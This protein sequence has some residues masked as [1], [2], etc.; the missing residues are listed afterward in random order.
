MKLPGKTIVLISVNLNLPIKKVTKVE[1]SLFYPLSNLCR[2]FYFITTKF[3]S[4]RNRE[5]LTLQ[6]SETVRSVKNTICLQKSRTSKYCLFLIRWIDDIPK[7][8]LHFYL[9]INCNR[10]LGGRLF[11]RRRKVDNLTSVLGLITNK[12]VLISMVDQKSLRRFFW[13]SVRRPRLTIR[14]EWQIYDRVIYVIRRTSHNLTDWL[15]FIF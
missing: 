15:R 5:S 3:P 14:R 11:W 12:Q 7:K 4:F 9:F 10:Q 1:V 6:G 13:Q 8:I 2:I